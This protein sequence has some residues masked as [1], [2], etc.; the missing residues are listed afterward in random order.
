MASCTYTSILT[1][2][3]GGSTDT[4]LAIGFNIPNSNGSY[5]VADYTDQVDLADKLVL[6]LGTA[7][8]TSSSLTSTT[9]ATDVIFTLVITCDDAINYPIFLY[10]GPL[11]AFYASI[12]TSP[13][14]TGAVTPTPGTTCL[15]TSTITRPQ[16]LGAFGASFFIVVFMSA[17]ENF[18]TGDYSVAADLLAAETSLNALQG[19][20]QTQLTAVEVG[21]DVVFTITFNIDGATQS[22]TPIG[23]YESEYSNTYSFICEAISGMTVCDQCY[24][25]RFISC[26]QSE[27]IFTGVVLTPSTNYN[28]TMTDHHGNE[29][30]QVQLTTDADG[31]ISWITEIDNGI[32]GL[33]TPYGGVYQFEFSDPTTGEIATFVINNIE[34]SCVAATFKDSTIL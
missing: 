1:H 13:C 28:I 21:S 12:F 14:D 20:T 8:V 27:Y 11:P 16:V 30:V 25:L 29:Y 32:T 4:S 26:A 18:F 31:I 23:F 2:P 10:S 22:Q 6:I 9:T 34:Y 17:S 7:T 24:P 3:L 19:I 33:F 15:Y 5:Y